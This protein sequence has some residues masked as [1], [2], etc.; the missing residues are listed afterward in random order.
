MRLSSGEVKN[1]LW[2]KLWLVELMLH[3]MP[4]D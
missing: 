3:E 2:M 4:I 1:A